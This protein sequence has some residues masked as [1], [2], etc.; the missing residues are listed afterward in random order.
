[1]PPEK[2]YDHKPDGSVWRRGKC[3]CGNTLYKKN[4]TTGTLEFLSAR[5]SPFSLDQVPVDGVTQFSIT[6]DQCQQKHHV[7]GVQEGIN[8]ND[9]STHELANDDNGGTIVT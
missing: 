9:L 6:C 3:T 5:R 2:D 7:I 8:M 1:M 4:L